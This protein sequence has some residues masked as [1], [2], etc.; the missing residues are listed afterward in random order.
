MTGA[1]EYNGE[2]L[3]LAEVARRENLPS[4]SLDRRY[5]QT[6]DIYKAVK[7]CKENLI[8]KVEY[9]GEQLPIRT[10]AQREGLTPH[11]LKRT[12][13]EIRDIY[14]A[15]KICKERQTKRKES[16]QYLDYSGET[17]TIEE[18]SKRVGVSEA[19]LRRAY[20]SSG[21]IYDAIRICKEN[22]NIQ[23][24]SV[25]YNGE[26]MSLSKIA[27]M[28]E[29][30]ATTLIRNYRKTGNIY[31]VVEQYKEKQRIKKI[32]Y[33]GKMLTLTAIAKMEGL[34]VNPLIKKYHEIGD[35]DKAV[36]LCK[37][38][39]QE[40]NGSIEYKGKLLTIYAIAERENLTVDLLSKKY[41]EIG[42]IY[43]AVKICKI[44]QQSKNA[45]IEYNGEFLRIPGIA[46]K[47]KI[48][49]AS[50]R[51]AYKKTGNIYE[52]V[53]ICK[54]NQNN[55]E[56]RKIEYYNEKLTVAAI[57]RK[58]N[59]NKE[60]LGNIYK[61]TGDIYEAVRRCRERQEKRREEVQYVEYY[62]EILSIKA[63]AQKEGIVPHSLKETYKKI[64]N[65][66][67]A[68]KE[69]KEK[70]KVHNGSI[71]YYGE[72]LSL[73]EIAQKTGIAKETLRTRYIETGNIYKAV[74]ICQSIKA[75]RERKKKKVDSKKYGNI[76]YYD[77][78]LIIGIKYG[79]LKNLLD[80]GYTVEQILN[81][82]LKP[83]IHRSISSRK[84][85]Q[86]PNGQS[87]SEYCIENNLNY[88]CIYR[89]INTYGKSLEEAVS[90]YN[91]Y[92]QNIP[93]TW[94]YEKYGIL[95]KHLLLKYKI[96]IKSVI[97]Y[98]RKDIISLDEAVEKYII[99]KNAK[100]SGLNE[101]WLEELYGVLTDESIAGEYDDYLKAFY[102]EDK[103]EECII[104]SIDET[105][106]FKRQEL[107]F[108]I[109]EVLREGIFEEN[110]EIE[111]L[112]MYKI[113]PK[114]IETIFLDLYARFDETG[115]L[116]GE[117]MQKEET[118]EKRKEINEKIRYYQQRLQDQDILDVMR[119]VVG[120][121]T[122]D[123][124]KTRNELLLQLKLQLETI[125]WS[126][127]LSQ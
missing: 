116:M 113:K 11:I 38:S 23:N 92:G 111:L 43:E 51:K 22:Q 1:I 85:I 39:Q 100:N 67:D 76:S 121:M 42:D 120:E 72:M 65:I 34:S 9:N 90:N 15:V 64:G 127:D 62:G 20:K 95:L 124:Q 33:K 61:E 4:T 122:K 125:V 59:L 83:T 52:A 60:I 8:E 12:Y 45:L 104:K 89:A 6:G 10:I 55:Q 94:I 56:N 71:E 50:L 37:Q 78:S 80:K 109:A 84:S 123:N 119:T 102:V 103:E 46:K 18:I 86:L 82:D 19:S 99:R 25:E 30:P 53:R 114:D 69:C 112:R 115:V 66:Y 63:V 101:E 5:K 96:D 26:Y 75:E 107:L 58:E 27:E 24:G 21:D 16:V 31:A 14:E 28:E 93:I 48:S 40:H 7:V 36:K 81:M 2:M 74:F 32:E 73:V 98:M 97:E 35:I 91:K 29:I 44:N 41:Q 106:H 87:L 79:E 17:L 110:E 77:L 117:K 57:A 68:V 118:P 108:E 70:K 126:Q 3:S 54:E 13:E 105:E 88:A 47:E 49:E